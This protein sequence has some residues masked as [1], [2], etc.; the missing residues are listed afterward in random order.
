MRDIIAL[1]QPCIPAYYK[2]V[3]YGTTVTDSIV[4]VLLRLPTLYPQK[5][6]AKSKE[7]KGRDWNCSP[8]PLIRA[9]DLFILWAGIVSR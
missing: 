4:N 3:Q 2:Q 5:I 9:Q 8:E 6:W 7:Q 1:R